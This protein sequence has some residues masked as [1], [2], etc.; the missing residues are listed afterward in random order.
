MHHK[1]FPITVLTKKLKKG[2]EY[3]SRNADLASLL[4]SGKGGPFLNGI[5]KAAKPL[6]PQALATFPRIQ[7]KQRSQSLILK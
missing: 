3:N 7:R 6:S 2:V 1:I 5:M 4:A